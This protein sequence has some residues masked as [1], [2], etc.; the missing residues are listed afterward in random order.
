MMQSVLE[1][2]QDFFHIYMYYFT[3]N[4]THV[5]YSYIHLDLDIDISAWVCN[6]LKKN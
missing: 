2:E 5:I 3:D 1:Y 4:Y 6:Y